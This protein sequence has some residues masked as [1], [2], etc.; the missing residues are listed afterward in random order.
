MIPLEMLL[1]TTLQKEKYKRKDNKKKTLQVHN[2]NSQKNR[3]F[4]T[5]TVALCNIILLS[6]EVLCN[7]ILPSLI[8]NLTTACKVDHFKL[9]LCL[10]CLKGDRAVFI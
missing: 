8:V 3:Y 7:K 5:S 4:V 2:L 9:K 10:S 1:S 6:T